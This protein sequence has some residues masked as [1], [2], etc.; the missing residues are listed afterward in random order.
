MA[1]SNLY[2]DTLVKKFFLVSEI[3]NEEVRP[4]M[5]VVLSNSNSVILSWKQIIATFAVRSTKLNTE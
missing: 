2:P 5:S 1:E 3:I 4:G